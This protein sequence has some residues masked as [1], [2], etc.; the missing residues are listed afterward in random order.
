MVNGRPVIDNDFRFRNYRLR[1]DAKLE[2][3]QGAAL[4]AFGDTGIN[5]TS[6]GGQCLGAAIGSG[7]FLEEFVKRKVECWIDEVKKLAL[8]VK[9]QPHA[10]NAAYIH[11][12]GHW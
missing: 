3:Q 9:T 5:I 10:A 2:Q 8:I 1:S 12:L 11:G 4:D 6:Q 7:D